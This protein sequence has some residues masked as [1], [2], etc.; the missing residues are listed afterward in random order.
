MTACAAHGIDRHNPRRYPLDPVA[1]LFPTLSLRAICAQLKISGSTYEAYVCHGV[2]PRTADR[3]A[4][5]LAVPTY[6]LWPEMIDDLLAESAIECVE[7]G[8]RFLRQ[9]HHGRTPKYCSARCRQRVSRRAYRLRKS[10]DPDWVA[11][12]RERRRAAYREARD[13]YVRWQKTYDDAHRD[14]VRAQ[15]RD[16]RRRQREQEQAA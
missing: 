5:R 14:Q 8:E 4:A 13:Y 1:D 9:S 7:C 10:Q 11:R 3:I 6:Y 16:L 12:Q 15:K 2:L